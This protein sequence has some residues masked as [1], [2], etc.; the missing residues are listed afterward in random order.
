LQQCVFSKKFTGSWNSF[1]F[2]ETAGFELQRVTEKKVLVKRRKLFIIVSPFK[3]THPFQS[4][5]V[6]KFSSN[7]VTL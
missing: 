5:F 1:F 4:Y 6:S 7:K 3:N 2:I